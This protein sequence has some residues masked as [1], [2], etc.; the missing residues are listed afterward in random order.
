M[1]WVEDNL[2]HEHRDQEFQTRMPILGQYCKEVWIWNFHICYVIFYPN[3]VLILTLSQNFWSPW[4]HLFSFLLKRPLDLRVSDVFPAQ[5]SIL[6]D[7]FSSQWLKEAYVTLFL[8]CWQRR[9]RCSLK[10]GFCAFI[11]A[12]LV[13]NLSDSYRQAVHKHLLRPLLLTITTQK[14]T[15]GQRQ[16]S[17]HLNYQPLLL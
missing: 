9:N 6:E 12:F 7:T 3:L 15:T 1:K 4:A 11:T 13:R 16:H 10:T 14:V 17:F 8:F 5:N 2:N